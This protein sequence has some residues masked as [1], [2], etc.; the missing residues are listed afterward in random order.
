VTLES[1][2]TAGTLYDCGGRAAALEATTV[3]AAR[4]TAA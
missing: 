3:E 4:E 1:S 2:S